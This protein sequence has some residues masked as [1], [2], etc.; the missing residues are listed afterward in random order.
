MSGSSSSKEDGNDENYYSNAEDET[1]DNSDIKSDVYWIA[2]LQAPTRKT[3]EKEEN[4]RENT[5]VY[6]RNNG[7][8]LVQVCRKMFLNNTGLE[9]FTI[10]S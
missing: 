7:R 5:M 6:R 3:T 4:R 1:N 9:R 8:K 10:E 2:H